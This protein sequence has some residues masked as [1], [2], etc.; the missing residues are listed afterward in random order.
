MPAGSGQACSGIVRWYGLE[1]DGFSLQCFG[2]WPENRAV[3]HA[4]I[5]ARFDA[6]I[7]AGWLEEAELLRTRGDLSPALPAL[8]A[9]GYPQWFALR[10]DPVLR[11][12]ARAEGLPP[13]GSW[14]GAS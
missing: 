9:V 6:M 7:A 1:E 10:W 8:R 13:P 2:L 5:E 12:E 14:L 4:C 11:G 3:L